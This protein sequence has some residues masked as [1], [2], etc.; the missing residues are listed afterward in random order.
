MRSAEKRRYT[1]SHAQED[2]VGGILRRA[3]L[4]LA[5]AAV[6]DKDG[7][8]GPLIDGLIGVNTTFHVALWQ[9]T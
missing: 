7:E 4:G 2:L 6:D 1:K 3:S 9:R 8:L 5:L